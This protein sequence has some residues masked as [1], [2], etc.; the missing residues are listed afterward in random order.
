MASGAGAGAGPPSE[1][2]EPGAARLAECALAQRAFG[3][4][5]VGQPEGAR[6]R[7]D[8]GLARRRH[9]HSG[10]ARAL[11]AALAAA[12]P[13]AAAAIAPYPGIGSRLRCLPPQRIP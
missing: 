13:L 10:W 5:Q 3:H 2:A 7:L 6:L 11:A 12:P 8:E 9:R 4:A 1:G